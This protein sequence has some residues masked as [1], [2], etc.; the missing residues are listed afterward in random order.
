MVP[1]LMKMAISTSGNGVMTNAMALGPT[2]KNPEKSK[3]ESGKKTIRL[4]CLSLKIK[5]NPS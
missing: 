1:T 3:Q 2:L 4:A 5:M